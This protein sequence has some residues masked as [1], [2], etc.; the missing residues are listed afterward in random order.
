MV[1]QRYGSSYLK[2]KKKTDYLRQNFISKL[3]NEDAHELNNTSYIGGYK[4]ITFVN[5]VSKSFAKIRLLISVALLSSIYKSC[6]EIIKLNM[7]IKLS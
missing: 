7:R 5:T 4:T 2:C 3:A 1:S 6:Y